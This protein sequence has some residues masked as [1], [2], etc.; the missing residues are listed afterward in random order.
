M[1]LALHVTGGLIGGVLTATYLLFL[2]KYLFRNEEVVAQIQCC[3]PNET[4]KLRD[5]AVVSSDLW[6]HNGHSGQW[7]RTTVI[8]EFARLS[9]THGA[10]RRLALIVLN[11][12]SPGLMQRYSDYRDLT[13][14]RGGGFDSLLHSRKEII[15]TLVSAAL[16]HKYCRGVTVS[17]NFKATLDLTRTDIAA[18]CAFTTLVDPRSV[19]VQYSRTALGHDF[20]RAIRYEFDQIVDDS[21]PMSLINEMS[22]TPNVAEVRSYLDSIKVGY[23]DSDEFIRD[24]LTRLESGYNPYSAI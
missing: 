23:D 8:P 5:A 20:Y 19:A 11:P 17:V 4:K 24:V 15:A 7:V 14:S 2:S 10:M 1:Q 21:T 22:R 16:T 12:D 18:D 9:T 3:E 13:G 6:L